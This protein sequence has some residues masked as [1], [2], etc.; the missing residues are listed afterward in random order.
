[1]KLALCGA[2]H[3]WRTHECLLY[4]IFLP[5]KSRSAGVTWIAA[6]NDALPANGLSNGFISTAPAVVMA[7][8]VD[9]A[10][11]VAAPLEAIASPL[12]NI[13]WR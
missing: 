12:H 1:M 6:Y 11:N 8:R 4:I 3:M 2:H 10:S 13:C 9:Q 5:A 7:W